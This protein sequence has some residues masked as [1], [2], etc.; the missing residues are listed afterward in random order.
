MDH[1]EVEDLYLWFYIPIK[2][3]PGK[4]C[5][6]PGG[7]H[8]Y[9]APPGIRL[10]EPASKEDISGRSSFLRAILVSS[11]EVLLPEGVILTTA[12]HFFLISF[13]VF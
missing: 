2:V 4:F 5:Q 12:S 7:V 13:A 9:A 3:Y 11:V 1:A 8:E 10:N 6:E